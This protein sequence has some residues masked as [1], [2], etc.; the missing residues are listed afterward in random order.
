M[1]KI[2][3]IILLA[4]GFTS[5]Q[6][7]IELETPT[8]KPQLNIDA[9]FK[10]YT[11]ESPVR[12]E[13]VIKITESVN[14]FE[15]DIPPI[16]NAIIT[17]TERGTTNSYPFIENEENTGVYVND[18][19]SFLNN[20]DAV[21]DLNITIDGITYTSSA[22]LISSTPILN[23]EQGD[24]EIFG[25]E[26]IEVKVSFEDPADI[27]NYY[28][29]DFE[30]NLYVPIRDE[31]FN[32]NFFQFSFLYTEDDSSDLMP[33]DEIT[34]S[35][36][37]IDKPFYNYMELLLEQVDGGG[38]FSSPPAI[39][40]GNILNPQNS[41]ENPLGYFRISEVFTKSLIIEED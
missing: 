2:L 38:P 35:C 26:D 39:V 41:K 19:L 5:C 13:G 28:L 9:H 10:V 27:E 31:F 40:R 8:G 29:F 11:E 4:I 23:L 15:D 30:F 6:D 33:G 18:D 37:G 17:M 24:L 12:T 25:E 21:F 1:K 7:V 34:V 3:Y 32:G 14:F 16:S 20:F 22:Q 36:E